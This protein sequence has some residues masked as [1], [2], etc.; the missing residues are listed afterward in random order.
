MRY[1][2]TRG[3]ASLLVGAGVA[4]I[5]AGPL[6]TAALLA[7]PRGVVSAAL[8]AVPTLAAWRSAHRWVVD[9]GPLLAGLLGGS[10]LVVA[11]EV[12]HVLLDQRDLLARQRATLQ[13]M[14][15][16]LEFWELVRTGRERSHLGRL[17]ARLR[18]EEHRA[19][20]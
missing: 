7:D 9:L 19:R 3:W 20:R 17:A 10:V 8:G 14:E 16:R 1:R 12:L 5:V 13:R 2:F 6:A 4:A 11:G 18:G 15:E